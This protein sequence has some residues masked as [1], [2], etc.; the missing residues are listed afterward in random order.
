VVASNRGQP[1]TFNDKARAGQAFRNIARRL[2]GEEVPYLNLDDKGGLFDRL[3]RM[4]KSGG[5]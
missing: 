1:V 2:L 3:S 5:N 4:I